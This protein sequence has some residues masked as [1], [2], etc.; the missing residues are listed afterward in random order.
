MVRLIAYVVRFSA[1]FYAKI[2]LAGV[3][4]LSFLLPLSVDSGFFTAKTKPAI[5]SL[6]WSAGD[7][8]SDRYVLA[9]LRP[10]LLCNAV[11][12][13]LAITSCPV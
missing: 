2:A 13:G 10:A 5:A 12:C 11:V 8:V 7:V 1:C 3:L 9:C 4:F 6:S